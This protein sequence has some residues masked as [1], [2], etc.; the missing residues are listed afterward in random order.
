MKT[1]IVIFFIAV[2]FILTSCIDIVQ[3]IG[4]QEEGEERKIETKIKITLQKALFE[5]ADQDL[6]PVAEEYRGFFQDLSDDLNASAENI[7]NEF[8]IGSEYHISFSENYNG[9]ET[10]EEHYFVP[11]FTKKTGYIAFPISTVPKE[12]QLDN[13]YAS[14][15]LSSSK[16]RLIISKKIFSSI[17]KVIL[18]IDNDVMTIVPYDFQEVYLLEIPIGLW[19]SA[20]KTC[21]LF[22]RGET[23]K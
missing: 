17:Q 23:E 20:K 2:L 22:I 19:F 7:E 3:Y 11:V 21:N 12:D 4:I 14:A 10:P 13:N 1:K 8:E 6:N 18:T 9:L 5:L 15:V 16:Y